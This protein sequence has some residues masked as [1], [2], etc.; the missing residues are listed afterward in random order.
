[1]DADP[2]AST[3][4]PP[5]QTSAPAAPTFLDPSLAA[6]HDFL[7]GTAPSPSAGSHGGGAAHGYT[8]AA[9]S[10][11]AHGDAPP[12]QP[13]GDPNHPL[14]VNFADLLAEFTVPA[15]AFS[16]DAHAQGRTPGGGTGDGMAGQ[17]GA[18]GAGGGLAG[19]KSAQDILMEQV[20]ML[21][22]TQGSPAAPAPLP[23]QPQPD[24]QAQ[25]QQLLA[26]SLAGSG[27]T[28]SETPTPTNGPGAFIPP[29]MHQQSSA[30]QGHAQ[31]QGSHYSPQSP[32]TF[33]HL[34]QSQ[35]ASPM[36]SYAGTS[37]FGHHQQQQQS[38]SAGPAT[39]SQASFGAAQNAFALP[40]A[41][42]QLMGQFQPGMGQ[43]FLPPQLHNAPL[44]TQ[45]AALQLLM[46]AQM[47][48]QMQAQVQAQMH[49]QHPHQ[50]QHQQNGGATGMQPMP[51][52]SN[53]MNSAAASLDGSYRENEYLFSPLMSPAMTPHSAFT[54]ASS[55]PPSVGPGAVPLVSPAEFFPPLTSPALGPQMYNSDAAPG[56]S[57]LNAHRNSLQGLVDGVGALSTQLPPPASPVGSYYSPRLG[58]VDAGTAT[59]AGAAAGRRGASSASKKTRPS[60]LIKPTPDSALERRRGR[61]KTVSSGAPGPTEKRAGSKSAT[62]SPFLGP[63]GGHGRASSVIS[64]SG[65]SSKASPGEGAAVAY[66]QQHGNGSAASIDTPSPVD[67]A[68]SALPQ[69]QAYV[70]QQPQQYPSHGMVFSLPSSLP[71]VIEGVAVPSPTVNPQMFAAP[72]PPMQHQQQPYQLEPMG[73]PPP[74]STFNPVTPA[75]FM[76]FSSDFDVNGLSSLSPALGPMNTHGLESALS[77]LNNSPALLPQPDAA[78]LPVMDLGGSA[79]PLPDFGAALAQHDAETFIAPPPPSTSKAPKRKSASVRASPALKP[80][81]A[82]GTGGAGVK[83]KGK[84]AANGAAG[85]K[86]A[87]PAAKIAPSP[88]IGPS[89]KIRPLLASG[90]APDAQARLASKSNYEN[91]LEGRGPDLLGL[92]QSMQSELQAMA[93]AAVPAGTADSRKSSHKVAEQKRRDSLKLCFDELRKLLP[94]ILP[95]TDELDRRP[96][97]GNVG[98]QRHGELDPNNPNRGVSKVALLRRSNEYL[99]ILRERIDRR[100]RA[101]SALRDQMGVLREQLGIPELGEDEEEVPGFDLDLD[102]LD[103]EEKQAGNLAFYEDLDFDQKV[104]PSVA[105]RPS[106]SSRRPSIAAESRPAAAPSRATGTR[107]SARMSQ[108]AQEDQAMADVE[109]EE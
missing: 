59:G 92:P 77:S 20:R 67:L 99:E 8:E 89:P 100:D 106:T 66:L 87:K 24:L 47:Q 63:V 102:N 83:G 9:A 28:T 62:S 85:A 96:G 105:R 11:A 53:G 94:P 84:A 2:S 101:I 18:G 54:N 7:S 80:V 91:I 107:R 78:F 76:N 45:V 58:P 49:Q 68:A 73:P 104:A 23:A 32:A 4:T 70:Q 3:R 31:P 5:F 34:P 41:F 57:R 95:Y 27:F 36:P 15:N 35:H 43:S 30:P 50:H 98:G 81:D 6:L 71:G 75:S 82:A 37:S 42:Q 108:A 12:P 46:N 17:D 10:P 25:L 69:Q 56:S 40:Q 19:A 39:P 52:M 79:Q 29:H 86:K 44:Q 21:Y 88:K 48:A 97:D 33:S 16:P 61:T 13:L 90:S 64:G 22:P 74:P 1:M 38:H 51:Q 109:A 26:A 72:P 55:L 65:S 103:K 93:P 14:A 60:P